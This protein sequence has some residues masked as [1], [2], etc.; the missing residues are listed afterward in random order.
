[1]HVFPV[2]QVEAPC[3][4]DTTTAVQLAQGA[5]GV[6]QAVVAASVV[7]RLMRQRGLYMACTIQPGVYNLILVF[8]QACYGV[9]QM[10]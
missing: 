1:M 3:T 9:K 5:R 8:D 6:C 4:T 7:P 2:V 10:A